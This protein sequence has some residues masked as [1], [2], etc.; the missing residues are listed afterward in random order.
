MCAPTCVYLLFN[1]DWLPR[2]LPGSRPPLPS[3][4]LMVT[5]PPAGSSCL[6]TGRPG[7]GR[8]D[9][10]VPSGLA[11]IKID[12]EGG[13]R[14]PELHWRRRPAAGLGCFPGLGHECRWLCVR[15]CACVHAHVPAHAPDHASRA[16]TGPSALV[17]K[18]WVAAG[19]MGQ[20]VPV[21]TGN[22]LPTRAAPSSSALLVSSSVR[23]R[24][25]VTLRLDSFQLWLSKTGSAA[26]P[27]WYLWR[28]AGEQWPGRVTERWHLAPGPTH[29]AGRGPTAGVGLPC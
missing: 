20:F 26:D 24:W 19:G 27:G 22:D 17:T 16:R 25:P 2:H 28:G 18:G 29:S 13:E 15:V 11:G 7:A 14:P 1:G 6:G 5:S 23:R 21:P 12:P 8:W 9:R 10:A 4:L 3:W